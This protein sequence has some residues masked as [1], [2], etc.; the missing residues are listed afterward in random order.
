M[1]VK[2]IY[3]KN[4]TG[5]SILKYFEDSWKDV[6][7]YKFEMNGKKYLEITASQGDEKPK[8]IFNE[9]KA[10]ENFLH[11]NH[12]EEILALNDI[13]ADFSDS[14]VTNKGYEIL[15]FNMSVISVNQFTAGKTTV[16]QK[17][18][19]EK[20]IP[21]VCELAKRV[22]NLLG[23][24]YAMI[25][26]N[27]NAQRKLTVTGLNTSPVIRNK[28]LNEM[29]DKLEMTLEQ[30]TRHYYKKLEVKLGAD[31]E[32]MIANSRTRKMIP[33]SDFFPRQGP[34]GCD[35]IRIPRR[36]QRPIAELRPQ[37][38]ISPIILHANIK[39]TLEQANKMAPYRNIKLLAGSQPFSGYSIGGHIHFSNIGLSSHFL[40]VLDN[41][42]GLPVFLLEDQQTAVKRRNKYGR[43]NDYRAKDYGG[44]E[45]RTLG[46]WLVSSEISLAVLCLAKLVSSNFLHLRNNYFLSIKAHRA[47]YQGETDY[48]R[49]LFDELWQEIRNLDDYKTYSQE[50]E[51]IPQ[52]IRQSQIWDENVD[53]RKTW[54]LNRNYSKR[55]T[56][57]NSTISATNINSRSH[58]T[59]SRRT[60]TSGSRSAIR[61]TSN[62]YA[63]ASYQSQGR[64][65]QSS[66]V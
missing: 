24:D 63:S 39:A 43:L 47:F 7:C 31:P 34:V 15:I 35:N 49:E 18:I 48:F 30:Y 16:N 61:S 13:A 41:Y 10:L 60:S 58:T 40:R 4:S 1:I 25:K 21:K 59:T 20:Q 33:A 57:K 45:Y 28:D 65:A 53:L 9:I 22:L 36:Q 62:T 64:Y 44:F 29:I 32:F 14:K 42:L 54:Y 17:Y 19:N 5:E 6:D 51:I 38:D 46:S 23:L 12:C 37:P 11:K 3:R 55:Y 66:H 52:M 26:I 27:I 50:L 2:M 8:V 56:A